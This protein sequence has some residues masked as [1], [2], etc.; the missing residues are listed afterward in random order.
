MRK[1]S[2]FFALLLISTVLLIGN[3]YGG[4]AAQVGQAPYSDGVLF[5]KLA[6]GYVPSRA[7]V[8]LGGARFGIEQ[9]DSLIESHEGAHLEKLLSTYGA[10]RTPAGRS[11]ERTFVLYYDDGTD[12]SE[13]VSECSQLPC[14][15]RAF[16][17]EIMTPCFYGVVRELPLDLVFDN[18]ESNQIGQWSLDYSRDS[19]DIDAP[20]AWAIEKGDADVVLCVIDTGTMLD[21]TEADWKVHSDFTYYRTEEDNATFGD[22]DWD[23]IDLEDAADGDSL[24]HL[25]NAKDCYIHDVSV[26]GVVAVLADDTVRVVDTRIENAYWGV[27]VGPVNGEIT[28]CTLKHN[29]SGAVALGSVTPNVPISECL[30]DSN[31]TNGIYCGN[32]LGNVIEGNTISNNTVG[33]QCTSAGSPTIKNGNTIEDNSTGIKCDSNSDPAIENGNLI[34]GNSIGIRCDGNSDPYVEWNVIS[35]NAI[36]VAVLNGSDPDLGD[37]SGGSIGNNSFLSSSSYHVSN[38]EPSVTVKADSNWWGSASGPHP[39]KI[40][41]AV[42]YTPWKT[43]A[44]GDPPSLVAQLPVPESPSLPDRFQIAAVYPNPFNPVTTIRYAVPSP[45]GQVHV[46]VYDIRGALVSTL[47]NRHAPPGYHSVNWAGR[48]EHG[49]PVASGVYFLRLSAE[50]HNETRKIVLLK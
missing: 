30:I 25:D 36:G 7:Q 31:A 12:P 5:L 21:T 3:Q 20:E 42:D 15:E 19:V 39:T 16:V 18:F 24:E 29:D 17:D 46:A 11:L 22:L 13:L 23:D 28:G 6:E 41:G 50:R 8:S 14:I 40:N 2:L 48:N 9:L 38:L 4:P 47:V 26:N 45:G 44:P 35:S 49:Q 33:I 27:T 1:Y 37:L 43:V 32:V 34:D 10:A